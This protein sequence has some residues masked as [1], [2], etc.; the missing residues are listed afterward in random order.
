M[1]RDM[2]H[3]INCSPHV[4]LTYSGKALFQVALS[5]IGIIKVSQF[6]VVQTR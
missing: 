1:L 2:Q 5:F 4:T 6:C 3:G